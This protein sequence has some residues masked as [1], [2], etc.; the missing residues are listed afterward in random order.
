[1]RLR[2]EAC[3]FDPLLSGM[4]TA[5][6]WRKPRVIPA[7]RG[8][9][10][11]GEEREALR[12]ITGRPLEDGPGVRRTA[13]LVGLAV[14]AVAGI[15][16]GLVERSRRADLEDERSAAALRGDSL[17]AALAA[18]D[19]LVAGRPAVEALLGILAAPDVAS[20]RLAGSTD[21]RGSLV[22]SSGGAIL[23]ASGLPADGAGYA[24]WHVDDAGS[25]HVV[26]LGRAPEGRLFAL[27][28]DAAFATGWGALQIA[29]EGP[30]T[31]TPG[32][33]VLEYRGFLR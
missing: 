13:I 17:T 3:M 4:A 12:G 6:E 11:S 14:L 29:R 10:A 28:D 18:R 20:F 24:L 23:S 27:L 2:V 9:P 15:A 25:H 19:S 8:R 21:A 26:D 22:A 5:S 30:A 33:I 31:G 32:E 7:H 1:M 16:Y